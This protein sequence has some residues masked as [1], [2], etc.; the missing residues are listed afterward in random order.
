M[1]HRLN[2]A[3]SRKWSKTSIWVFFD[4][5]EVKYPQ[6]ENF[7]EKKVSFKLKV[8]FSNNFRPKTKKIV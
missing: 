8:T 3:K 7:Y 2:K 1:Y 4:N 6:I 5:F